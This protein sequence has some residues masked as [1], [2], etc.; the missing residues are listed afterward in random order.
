M[1]ES[2]RDDQ[3]KTECLP[4]SAPC[5]KNRVRTAARERKGF[6]LQR[7]EMQDGLFFFSLTPH[8]EHREWCPV[9][10][11]SLY[12]NGRN[13][14]GAPWRKSTWSWIRMQALKSAAWV[15][16]LVLLFTACLL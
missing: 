11:I 5:W 6:K 15:G 2:E 12:S 9:T 3:L 1:N 4:L 7:K 16:N 13:Q 10:L 14:P 8:V